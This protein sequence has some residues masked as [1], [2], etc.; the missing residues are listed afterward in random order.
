M[1][2]HAA[3]SD[4]FLRGVN[5]FTQHERFSFCGT[6]GDN[7][8][9]AAP[10]P[11]D[12]GPLCTYPLN[13]SG[14]NRARRLFLASTRITGRDFN[15]LLGVLLLSSMFVIVTNVAVDLLQAWIDPRTE[16]S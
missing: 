11:S 1:G 6:H 9:H 10:P 16:A 12:S 13:G 4:S 2:R 3:I 7:T 8:S 14:E 5:Y 15:V